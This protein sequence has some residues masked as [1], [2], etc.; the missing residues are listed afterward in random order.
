MRINAGKFRSR[1]IKITNL[2]TT[3]ETS[4]KVRQA[5]FNM[6]GQ[7]FD[8]G[9]ALD[10]FA[11]S[12]AMGLEAYSR[13]IAKVYFNDINNSALNIVKENCKTLDCIQDVVLTNLDYS[14]AL[15]SLKDI[16]FN[17]VFLDPPYS[18]LEVDQI[19]DFISKNDMLT[20]DGIISLEMH[21]DTKCSSQI[22]DLIMVKDK[23]YGIKR[24]VL[25]E[26]I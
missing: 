19:I 10:L 22:G 26:R 6:V 17:V 20:K 3:K 23:T 24:V 21:R 15:N 4:D 14:Q 16:K 25:F 7:Y 13:G 11:G 2:D 9:I 5:I 18:F 8:G 1:N 12:G